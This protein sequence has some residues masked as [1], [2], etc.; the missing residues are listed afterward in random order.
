MGLGATLGRVK[1]APRP[2]GPKGAPLGRK[3]PDSNV[4]RQALLFD[5]FPFSS[6]PLSCFLA[7]FF[8]RGLKIVPLFLESEA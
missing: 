1:G 2:E 8:F 7:P 4:G 5:S 6:F 3:A